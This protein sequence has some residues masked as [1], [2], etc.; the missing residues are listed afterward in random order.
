MPI[1]NSFLKLKVK[2]F[3]ITP[4]YISGKLK[5]CMDRLCGI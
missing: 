2:V 3:K 4:N 1:K 5:N